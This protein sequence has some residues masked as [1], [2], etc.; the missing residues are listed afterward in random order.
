MPRSVLVFL[1]RADTDEVAGSQL[2]ADKISMTICTYGQID[3][4]ALKEAIIKSRIRKDLAISIVSQVSM[5]EYKDK[6]RFIIILMSRLG[7]LKNVC[8]EEKRGKLLRKINSKVK[9]A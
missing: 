2:T 7:D 6:V 8:I 5:A 3:K 4:T 9:I 1:V